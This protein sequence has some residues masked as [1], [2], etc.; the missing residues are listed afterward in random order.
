MKQTSFSGL[1]GI[2]GFDVEE[3]VKRKSV[4]S[5]KRSFYAVRCVLFIFVHFVCMCMCVKLS[6]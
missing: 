3:Y 4:S 2:Q 6:E 5:S 1:P